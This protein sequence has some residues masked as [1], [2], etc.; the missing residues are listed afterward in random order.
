MTSSTLLE[1]VGGVSLVL[2][3]VAEGQVGEFYRLAAGVAVA[4]PAVEDGFEQA[5]RLGE[6]EARRRA[7]GSRRSS[8]RK[9]WAVVTSAVW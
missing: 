2:G 5:D 8:V 6:C 7:F 9:A 1:W 3:C 4:G